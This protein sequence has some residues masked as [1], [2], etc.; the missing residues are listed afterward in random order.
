MTRRFVQSLLNKCFY[1]YNNDNSLYIR[2]VDETLHLN[3]HTRKN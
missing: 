2:G 3:V 1:V